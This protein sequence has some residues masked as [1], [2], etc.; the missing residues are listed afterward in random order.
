MKTLLN[1]DQLI[2]HMKTKGIMFNEV[3]EEDAKIFLSQHNYYMK[4]AS[5][6][7]NYKKHMFGERKGQYI[8]FQRLI[9]I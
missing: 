8:N 7:A 6:R 9:C 4:L 1:V 3:S 5:Y 2:E